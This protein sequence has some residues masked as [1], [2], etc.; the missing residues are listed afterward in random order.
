MTTAVPKADSY[1]NAIA[2]RGNDS[3]DV[4]ESARPVPALPLSKT[5]VLL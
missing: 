5:P 4:Q 2:A 3:S 1:N